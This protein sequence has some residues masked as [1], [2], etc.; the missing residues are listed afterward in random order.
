MTERTP[1]GAEA[2]SSTGTL[3]ADANLAANAATASTTT[4]TA[5]VPTGAGVVSEVRNDKPMLTVYFESAKSD[6]S[7]DMAAAAKTLKAYLDANPT[8]KL[9]VSGYND[10]SGNA[11]FNAELSKKRAQAVAA[12]LKTAGIPDASV[13]LIKPSEATSSDSDTGAGTP[14]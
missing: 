4:A 9:A 11:V 14:R 5:A 3:P 8:A 6:V 10:P 2:T 7:N 13:E 1:D 12:A